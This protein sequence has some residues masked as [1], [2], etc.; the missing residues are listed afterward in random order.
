M[1]SAKPTS[2][3]AARRARFGM[4]AA[5]SG[6]RPSSS[7]SGSSAQP[8]GTSTRYFIARGYATGASRRFREVAERYGADLMRRLAIVG[9]IAL[10]LALA[11][12][13]S[14]AA[15]PELR[16]T[17]LDDTEGLVAMTARPGTRTLYIAEQRGVIWSLAGRQRSAR[18]VI[19]LSGQVRQDGGERGLL[20]LTFSPDGR[21]L[22]VHYS[23]RNGN[24][25]VDRYAMRR[26]R[27]DPATRSSILTFEQPQPNHNGGELV[28]GPDG[29]LYLGLGDGGYAGDSGPGHAPG[30]N[31][32][33]LGTL[34]GKIVRIDPTAASAYSVPADNPFVATAGARPEIWSYGLRNPWRFS[35]D[36]E[37]GDLWIGDVGQSEYEEIDRVAATSGRDA[38]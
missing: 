2:A 7:A 37:T 36:Q 21:F 13:P 6:V 33:S 1:T 38:G 26:G 35:F 19:D 10:V 16:L 9:T 15:S 5:S 28:F 18:P 24:T 20:G 17:R 27:A 14:E 31:G 8:S 11:A 34:L 4:R 32:Q 3:D 22:Y 23:D 30:G 12:P 25:A 29:Y